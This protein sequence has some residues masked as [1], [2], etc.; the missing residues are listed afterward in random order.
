[1][2]EPTAEQLFNKLTRQLEQLERLTTHALQQ[3]KRSN[4][5]IMS[6]DAIFTS[7]FLSMHLRFELFLE[8]LFYSCITGSSEI[9][10]CFPSIVFKSRDQ[11]EIIFFGGTSFPVWMPY[12]QGA[13]K[14]AGRAFANGGPFFR[15]QKQTDER[16]FLKSMSELRNAIAHQS[17]SA[18]QKVEPLTSPMRPRRRTPAGYLQNIVQGQTQYAIYSSS[19]LVIASS[20][21]QKSLTSAKNILSPEDHFQKGENASAGKYQCINC[22]KYKTLRNKNKV[23]LGN[24]DRCSQKT[25]AWRRAY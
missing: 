4:L 2:A 3:R 6:V 19:L 15:L 1:M 11:A 24:C 7:A 9:E 12:T 10:D 14:I 5:S 21:S 16:K 23:E 8:D 25:K 17:K 18:L 22:G 13:E 20:L